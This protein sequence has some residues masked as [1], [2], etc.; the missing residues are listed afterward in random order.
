MTRE[1]R[2]LDAR[3]LDCL[4]GALAHRGPDGKGRYTSATVGLINTRLAIIDL[5]TGDQPL[6]AD[7]GEVLVANG[8]IY[9]D[10]ELRE[11]LRDVQFATRSDCEPPLYVYRRKG[12]AF[13]ES[14]RGMYAIALHEPGTHRLILARDPF[15]IKQLYYRE[16]SDCLAF[17]S[18][19]QALIA[20]GLASRSIRDGA[21]TELLQL[22]FTTGFDTIFADIK[23]VLPGETLI[24]QNGRITG[25]QR[26]LSLRDGPS[27][28]LN[29]A[30]AL[31]QLDRILAD[32]VL[33]HL[34]SDVPY[35]LFLSSGIDSSALA[36]LIARLSGKRLLAFTATFPGTAAADESVVARRVAQAVGADHHLVEVRADDFWSLA[37]RVAA[38]LDDPTTD[39]AT[40][41]TYALAREARK[42]VKVVLTGEGGDEIFCGYSR[43]HR[44]RRLWGLFGRRKAR[45]RGEFDTVTGMNEVFDGWRQGL[46]RAEQGEAHPG[47]SLIQTLQAIDCAEWLPNDLLIKVDRCLMAN[48]V[49]GR[50][51]FLDPVVAD[52]A[53]RLPDEMKAT[54]RISKRLLRDWVAENLPVAEPYARKKGFNPPIREWLAAFQPR[55]ESL[56]ASQPGIRALFSR[57]QIASAF[58]DLK[59]HYQAAWSL[60]FYAL[61]HSHHVLEVA[62]DGT[63]EDVL[64]HAASL[65]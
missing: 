24:V 25:R 18:E 39:P 27:P 49:E 58:T 42:N 2:P 29:H 8:E 59:Q 35:G 3:L 51:P 22:K 21:V 17:A 61:W 31:D 20:A 53:F 50:T 56:V 9:N 19:P 64:S 48:G 45:S 7:R 32:T 60:V 44:A 41:P 37:P 46:S 5:E 54:S 1:G 26:Q 52:F 6:Y 38:A 62:A 33:H 23:R 28:A 12:V 55:L 15:G 43:Y 13:A 63:V 30:D 36:A 34:R 4:T 16:T 57:D 65:G 47:R 10:P 14:L 11:E 40:I